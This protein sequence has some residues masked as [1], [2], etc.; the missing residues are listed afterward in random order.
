MPTAFVTG[1]TG[2]LGTHLI[3]VLL[4]EGWHVIALHRKNSDTSNLDRLGCEKALG[5]VADAASLKG[6]IPDGTDGV[7][8]VAG[9]TV[10]WRGVRD[11]QW[12]TNVV[13]TENMIAAALEAK[14]GRFVHTSSI[15]VYGH[16]EELITEATPKLGA[17][18]WV[19]Y[20]KSK[21]FAEKAVLEAVNAGLDAVVLNPG[22]ILGAY[23]KDNWSQLFVLTQ[24][25][26]LPG[27]PPGA[28]CF[29]NAREVAR[30]HLK[31]YEVGK[32]GENYFLGGPHASFLEVMKEI[33]SLL[34]K[35][36]PIK[37][38]P[39]VLLNIV[40]KI[41][42]F[43]SRF[44]HKQPN[45][46]PELA[47]FVC[48]DDNMSSTKAESE[49]GYKIIPIKTSLRQTYAWLIQTGILEKSV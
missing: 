33:S 8:H 17:T 13:G 14:V 16:H 15:A 46:T 49:L 28:G 21:F 25:D 5:D 44:T 40:A 22:H 36:S 18:S 24:K 29:A 48:D 7:F 38:T 12:Q 45:F 31:A 26:A 43:I 19:C 4:E 20:V 11:R 9:N 47:Y 37:T 2:F 27:V 39:A 35:K 42:D 34:G 1:G 41:S 3:E 10:P 6:L 23:D 30:A 32:S